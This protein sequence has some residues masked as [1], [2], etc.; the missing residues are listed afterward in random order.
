MC[1]ACHTG[2]ATLSQGRGPHQL[3]D[4][5]KCSHSLEVVGELQVLVE[6]VAEVGDRKGV[7]PVVVG[8]IPVALL[9]HQT[10]PGGGERA[11]QGP[12]ALLLQE[13]LQA[14][15]CPIP[16]L[17]CGPSVCELLLTHRSPPPSQE[18]ASPRHPQTVL[19]RAQGA[20]DVRVELGGRQRRGCLHGGEGWGHTPGQRRAVNFVVIDEIHV[21]QH[22]EDGLER[23]ERWDQRIVSF[24]MGHPTPSLGP[25]WSLQHFG[26]LEL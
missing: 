4:G 26:V 16:L 8:W 21:L 17:S 2:G 12:Q 20:M 10:E 5:G 22:A 7:H 15:P 18:W 6:Q 13:T 1:K 19:P 25:S 3:P 14:L 23:V 9:H 24:K 11:A